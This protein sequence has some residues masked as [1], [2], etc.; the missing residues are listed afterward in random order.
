MIVVRVP[1]LATGGAGD[2]AGGP[3]GTVTPEPGTGSINVAGARAIDVS[4]G[5]SLAAPG[6][7]G[8]VNG[9]PRQRAAAGLHVSGEIFANGGSISQGGS[10]NGADGGRVDIELVPT[11]GA[12]MIDQSAKISA[13]GGKSARRAA[14]PAAAATSGCSRWTATSPS[15]A[16]SPRAAATATDGRHRRPGRHNLFLQRQQPQRRRRRKG[17]PA[18]RADRQA[19]LLGRRRRDRR[20]RAQRRDRGP[21]WRRSRGAGEVRDLPQLRRAA[22]RDAQLDEERRNPDRA[23]RRSQRQRR[24][25]HLSR[26][27]S[28]PARHARRRQRQPPS[29]G[30]QPGHVRRRHR[31]AGRLR[32]RMTVSRARGGVLT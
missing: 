22:R 4:G 13:D 19:R 7:G 32:R 23:R 9:S 2:G 6:A 21:A 5:D 1:V 8:H 29:A 30:G 20:Q 27:R 31:H 18:D 28:R 10:G 11:D 12:V 3:G 15:P 14:S 26:H 25:H 17:K 16:R 24:R